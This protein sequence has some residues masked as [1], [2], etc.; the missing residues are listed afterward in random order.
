[1]TAARLGKPPD[2]AQ[3]DSAR[4]LPVHA[5]LRVLL[6]LA[7][8]VLVLALWQGGVLNRLFGLQDYTVPKPSAIV[9]TVHGQWSSVWSAQL[10]TFT[11]AAI[12]YVIG[13]ALG[14]AAAVLVTVFGAGRR[15][16]PGLAGAVNALPVVALAPVAVVYLGYGGS[17]KIAVVTLLT[18]AVMT[19]NACKGLNSVGPDQLKLMHSYAATPAQILIKVRVPQSLPYLFTALK[20]NVAI[21]LVCAIIAEFFGAYGGV[22]PEMVQ[23]LSAFAM[24]LAWGVM[25]IMGLTGIICYQVIAVIERLCT[26]WQPHQRKS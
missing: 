25:L 21:A 11:E 26:G 20:Y 6:P 10:T 14:F 4:G 2:A 17:S 18:A 3:G 13:A 7:A 23:A 12:G 22:G 19:L 8:L 1:M 5:V 15:L 24:P 9:S 16:V